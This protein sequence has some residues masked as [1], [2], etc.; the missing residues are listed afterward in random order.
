MLHFTSN[1][2]DNARRLT[3]EQIVILE[4]ENASLRERVRLMEDG[5]L[6]NLT[7]LVGENFNQGY[8]PERFKGSMK[9]CM[10]T[11]L[12]RNVKTEFVLQNWK[13]V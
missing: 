12:I 6:Q 10:K 7:I 9:I 4:K 1:P 13:K 5:Q 8:T 11:F 2:L 3:G